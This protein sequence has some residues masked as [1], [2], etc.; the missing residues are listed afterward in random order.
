MNMVLNELTTSC[1]CSCFF[2]SLQMNGQRSYHTND[3][4]H[5]LGV[6][7]AGRALLL[8]LFLPIFF[9]SLLSHPLLYMHLAGVE[10]RT[11][12]TAYIACY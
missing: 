12:E 10:R 5:A 9:D 3:I 11:W 4:L 8:L 1:F 6:L 2:C 7:G